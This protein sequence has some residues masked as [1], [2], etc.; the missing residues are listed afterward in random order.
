[1]PPVTE[2][3]LRLLGVYLGAFSLHSERLLHAP[4]SSLI[5]LFGAR[6]SQLVGMFSLNITPFLPINC[7]CELE[8]YLTILYI[9][10]QPLTLLLSLCVRIARLMLVSFPFHTDPTAITT[11]NRMSFLLHSFY[12]IRLTQK[13]QCVS[14]A[15]FLP[16]ADARVT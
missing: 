4:V 15:V 13:S 5:T 8:I 16:V 2:A 6:I 12:H 10:V 14:D 7:I 3:V 11:H 9:H 1:M